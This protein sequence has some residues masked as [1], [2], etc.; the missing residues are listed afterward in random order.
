MR[1][2]SGFLLPTH[3]QNLSAPFM[4]LIGGDSVIYPWTLSER[5]YNSR[6]GYCHGFYPF[7]GG[8]SL[9]WSGWCPQPAL[10]AL[11]GFPESMRKAAA[12]PMFWSRASEVLNVVSTTDMDDEAFGS[13]QHQLSSRLKFPL[14]DIPSLATSEP[15]RLAGRCKKTNDKRG[16]SKFCAVESLLSLVHRQKHRSLLGKGSLL[17]I[18]LNCAVK[19]IT[20]RD[21]N[22]VGLD[23]SQG[24]FQLN[25]DLTK[26]V[27]CAGVSNC[28]FATALVE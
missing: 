11:R 22:V 10:K 1:S 20:V 25:G 15:A 17:D 7:F 13:L 21:G 6:L 14:D 4:N 18:R 9:F 12:D 5:T 16:F 23:T 2:S 26:L 27:L 8:R 28:P 3:F 24:H 19:A